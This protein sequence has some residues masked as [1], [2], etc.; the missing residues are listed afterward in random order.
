LVQ[1]LARQAHGELREISGGLVLPEIEGLPLEASVQLA[2]QRHRDMTGTDVGEHYGLLPDKVGH[3]LKIC[4]YRVVQEALNNASSHGRG[5]GQ[6]V[7]ARMDG[8]V[9]TVAVSDGGPGWNGDAGPTSR[10]LGLDGIRN[11]VDAFG[12]SMEV[13]SRKDKGTI[14]VVRVPL[15]GN[16]A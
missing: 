6:H 15:D 2:V 11:R 7:D 14:L 4:L 13:R 10:Q 9:I 3:P 12:G 8:H 5:Q 1:Q 16:G